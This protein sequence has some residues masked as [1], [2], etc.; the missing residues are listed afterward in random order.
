[1]ATPGGVMIPPECGGCY[2]IMFTSTVTSSNPTHENLTLFFTLCRLVGSTAE[3][4]GNSCNQFIIPQESTITDQTISL[5]T[6]ACLTDGD[7]VDICLA[8]SGAGV[9]APNRTIVTYTC[10]SFSLMRLNSCVV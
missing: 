7:I 1:M 2:L 6:I 8:G 4:L 3:T 5:Q 9:G 10:P